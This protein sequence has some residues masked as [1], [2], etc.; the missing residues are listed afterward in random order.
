MVACG[1]IFFFFPFLFLLSGGGALSLPVYLS[2][3][4]SNIRIFEVGVSGTTS[5][6][7]NNHPHTPSPRL[8]FAFQAVA[9]LMVAGLRASCQERKSRRLNGFD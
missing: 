2:S 9:N 1:T 3:L 7:H 6:L 4:K 8:P 5:I